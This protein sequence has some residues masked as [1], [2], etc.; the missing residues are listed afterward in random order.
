MTQNKLK[1]DV[2]KLSKCLSLVDG[3]FHLQVIIRESV[4]YIIDVTRRIPGDLYPY[5]MEYC[6]AVEYSKAVVKLYIGE[7]LKGELDVIGGQKFVIRHCVMSE[8]NGIFKEIQLDKSLEENIIFRIDLINKDS[9][10]TNFL[11][12]QIAIIF[13]QVLDKDE[14]TTNN[15]NKLIQPRVV[16]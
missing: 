9:E 13:V 16:D 10:I 8:K 15:I 14:H 4:P 11:T 5:L 12:D 2:E 3:M 7:P 6:D 1:N